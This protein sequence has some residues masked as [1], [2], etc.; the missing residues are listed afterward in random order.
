MTFANTADNTRTSAENKSLPRAEHTLEKPPTLPDPVFP[1]RRIHQIADA[2]ICPP[3]VSQLWNR[4]TF[5]VFIFASVIRV[6]A[7]RETLKNHVSD[8]KQSL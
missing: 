4:D 7:S 5:H 2:L 8:A 1:L 3:S 6:L